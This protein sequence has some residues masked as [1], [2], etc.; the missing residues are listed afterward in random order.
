MLSVV[1]GTISTDDVDA[2]RTFLDLQST[3]SKISG[4]S[5]RHGDVT[6]KSSLFTKKKLEGNRR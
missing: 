2:S 5:E 1:V 4:C 3:V 6:V